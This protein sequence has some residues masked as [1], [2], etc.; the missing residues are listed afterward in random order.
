MSRMKKVNGDESES[1]IPIRGLETERELNDGQ[2]AYS[3]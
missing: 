2:V 3:E 1:S